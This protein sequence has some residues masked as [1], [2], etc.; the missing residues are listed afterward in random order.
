MPLS[1][2]GVLT[3]IGYLPYGKSTSAGP[4]GFT[5]QRIDL[6]T[7]G[8]YYYRARHY[9]PAWG[10]FLQADPSG[11]NSGG[12][13]YAYVRNDPLNLVDSMGLASES[14]QPN[15]GYG[16]GANGMRA[17]DAWNAGNYGTAAF[18][19][20]LHTAE[21]AIAITPF[22]ALENAAA[23]TGSAL[24]AEAAPTLSAVRN[25]GICLR[26]MGLALQRRV[27]VISMW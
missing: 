20:L 15:Y 2:S 7:N 3:K 4:F 23:K 22:G 16:Y 17:T 24:V 8:L 5:G 18:Y 10:R 9:S 27:M 19:E 13:L 26:N 11:A 1:T 6:E 21:T 14:P 25:G 12:S